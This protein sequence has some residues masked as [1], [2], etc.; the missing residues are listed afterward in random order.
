MVLTNVGSFALLVN[1]ALDVAT[2][3][4][5]NLNIFLGVQDVSNLLLYSLIT[6]TMSLMRAIIKT[7]NKLSVDSQIFH[8]LV[9]STA[10]TMHLIIKLPLDKFSPSPCTDIM[11]LLNYE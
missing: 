6:M 11:F 4:I 10:P 7:I 2:L 5:V 9:V 1:L 8:V 3:D